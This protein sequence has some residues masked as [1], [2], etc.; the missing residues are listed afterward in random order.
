MSDEEFFAL[1]GRIGSGQ[2]YY[3]VI[4]YDLND[5]Y[6]ADYERGISGSL[7]T[8]VSSSDSM[9]VKGE[10]EM[11]IDSALGDTVKYTIY[12][13]SFEDDMYYSYIFQ[14]VFPDYD[15]PAG[16]VDISNEQIIEFAKCWFCVD[17]VFDISYDGYGTAAII[18]T[19]STEPTSAKVTLLGDVNLDDVVGLADL[20]TVSKYNL[21]S[22]LFPLKDATAAA[23]ADMNND[24]KIDS[25]DEDRLIEFNLSAI[26]NL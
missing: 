2:I 21:N 26:D 6:K 8:D 25:L 7:S 1:N 22:T 18:P 5:E 20:I 19:P 10:T 3:N 16:F 23:N 12:S 24:G 9:Y 15:F 4:N 14:I 17:Q 13:P 11:L